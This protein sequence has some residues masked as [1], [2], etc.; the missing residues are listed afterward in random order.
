APLRGRSL[1]SGLTGRSL[2]I[3]VSTSHA[4]QRSNRCPRSPV[5]PR[6]TFT[7]V[8]ALFAPIDFD[9]FHLEDLPQRLAAGNGALAA[10]DLEGVRPIAFRLDDGRSYT[11]TP[12]AD[13]I[14]ITPGEDG[15]RTIVELSHQDWSDFVWE[16]RSCF[17][18]LYADRIT[19]PVGS[20]GH[21]AR[22]EPA[23]RAAFDGQVIYD[24]AHPAAVLDTAGRPLD[25]ERSFSL[26]DDDRELLDFLQRAGY[27]HLRSVFSPAEIEAMSSDVDAAVAD[28]RPDDQRSWWTTVDGQA[29]CNRV[30]Y[31]NERSAIIA[32]LDDDARLQRI[33]ALGGADLR[34][35]PDRL[36]GHGVVVKVPGA[37]TGLA[38]LPWHR[39]CGMGGHSVKCPM[40]NVG[41]QLD[42]ATAGSGQLHM[43]AGSHRGTSRMPSDADTAGLPVVAIA[44]Q[45]GDVTVHYGHTLHAAPPPA[46]RRASGRRALYVSFVPPLTFEMVGPGHGYNDVL[47]TRDEGR[48]RHIDELR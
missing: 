47:F 33:G 45:P 9:R 14:E 28:A 4:G 31:L 40:L 38:D 39:D 34:S 24:L 35:A 10:A 41:I 18:L 7:L 44:T 13:G 22:W 6:T 11:Y 42:A 2:T 27:V 46:D 15:A 36:D 23:L 5:G 21:L 43:I 32:G 30:N 8:A 17:A 1:D 16:L 25:L 37:E 3:A 20:F 26:D 19:F 48:V 12:N 29:V